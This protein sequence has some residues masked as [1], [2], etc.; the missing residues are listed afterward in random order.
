MESKLPFSNYD[1]WAYLA[2][3]F[4]LL[5][6]VDQVTGRNLL[7]RESWTVVQGVIAV[8]LAYVVGHVAAGVSAWLLEKNLVGRCL[9]YPR[10]ILFGQPRGRRWLWRIWP[11]YFAPM[12]MSVQ[13][14]VRV[15]ASAA[16][17]EPEAMFWPAYHY[18]RSIPAAAARLDSFLNLY[19]FCR[20]ISL[21]ALFDAAL[22][23]WSYMQPHGPKDHLLWSR[24]ALVLSVAMLGRYLK[25]YRHFALDVFTTWAYSPE[26]KS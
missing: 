24:C 11:G 2:A 16:D 4:L 1:F 10:D 17:L 26:K 18:T 12:P 8:S 21:V 13:Q 23:Y 3:G 9:G 15:R 14:A 5:F 6:A 20:N 25:F 19:G 7:M 22:F